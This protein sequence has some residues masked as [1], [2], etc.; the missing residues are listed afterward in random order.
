VCDR[1]TIGAG[2]VLGAQLPGVN[3]SLLAPFNMSVYA[4][5]YAVYLLP[6]MLLFGAMV[7]AIVTFSRNIYAGF[8]TV[9]LLLIAREVLVRALAG[10]DSRFLAA[11]LKPFGEVAT[12]FYTRGW[13]LAE[14]NERALPLEG[15]I[16]YNRFLALAISAALVG[17]VHKYFTFSQTALSFK[18][19]S[20]NAERVVKN[21]FGSITKVALPSVRCDFSFW[22]R[23][24]AAWK[25]SHLEFKYIV[26]S[27]AF[28]SLFIVG[29]L[30]VVLSMLQMN[31]QHGT[32]LL[33]ATWV[34]LAFPILFFSLVINLLTFL[35][36][37]VLVHRAKVA[38]INELV[39]VTPLPN[40]ALLLSKVI[41]LIKMQ[42]LLLAII[43]FAG[44]LVQT[45]KG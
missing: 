28:I 20:R 2:F 31:P 1:V 11:L 3:S 18:R 32:R 27:G 15:A 17:V 6:N 23:L 30:F 44:V 41:A 5:I 40:W 8:I 13:T 21:N 26:T 29:V 38:R 16:I 39:D 25:L 43:M 42:A 36:A 9:V 12:S 7:F 45:H 19:K 24:K 10:M 4:Q 37:G 22:Q 14:Q 35:Y 33:P 34:M